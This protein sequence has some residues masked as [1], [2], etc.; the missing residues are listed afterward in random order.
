MKL[1]STVVAVCAFTL[2]AAASASAQS[3]PLVRMDLD[4]EGVLPGA[5]DAQEA[6]KPE[7]KTDRWR[8]DFAMYLWMADLSGSMDLGAV[9]G[10]LDADFSDLAHKLSGALTLHMEAWRNDRLGLFCDLNWMA[11]HDDNTKDT[12]LGAIE[13]SA[14]IGLLFLE[15]AAAARLREGDI[16][17]DFF[18][19]VRVIAMSTE[20]DLGPLKRDKDR[21]FFDP[22][23]GA[24]FRWDVAEWFSFLFRADVAGF[25]VGTEMTGN[26]AG[27]FA[28]NIGSTFKILLGW[29]A[30]GM[31]FK[32]AQQSVDVKM[33]GPVLGFDLSF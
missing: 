4:R 25:G 26:V 20:L 21:W 2:G 1:L 32:D 16:S 17:V 12:A 31:E 13:G 8:F 10:E 18:A 3:E 33:H 9:S 22:M 6:A 27:Y 28:Y 14:D 5:A 30:M 23:I 29:R 7:A 24:R 15:G 11:F 19:G